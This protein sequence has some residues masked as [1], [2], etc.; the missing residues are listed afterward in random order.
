MFLNSIAS[1]YVKGNLPTK[2]EIDQQSYVH[3]LKHHPFIARI[4]R[5]KDQLRYKK[6]KYTITQHDLIDICR[7]PASIS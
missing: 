2:V 1:K 5:R 3:K 7:T 4:S 6:I